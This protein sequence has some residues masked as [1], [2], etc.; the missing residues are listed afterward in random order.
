MRPLNKPRP[1]HEAR[2][3][4]LFKFLASDRLPSRNLWDWLRGRAAPTREALLH[5]WNTLSI[6]PYETIGAPLVGR[7]EQANKWAEAKYAA[8]TPQP[9][10]EE[11][12]REMAGYYV[13]PLATEQEALPV[14]VSFGDEHIFRGEF[15]TYC[16]DLIGVPLVEEAWETKLAPKALDYG[17][18]LLAAADVLADRYGLRH[19]RN[20]RSPESDD[21]QSVE[22]Q[23]H[24]VYAL[25]Q[26]L[27]F[28]AERGHGYEADY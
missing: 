9:P 20:T 14:Y 28:F 1:G 26:W 19:L 24:I 6:T 18:R 13:V 17:R 25:A 4:A 10:K 27:V 2:W 8:M 21:A 16:V 15:L 12:W 22:W 7:D 3:N 5:E 23:L 11:Y